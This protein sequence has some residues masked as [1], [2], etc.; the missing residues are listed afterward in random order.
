L[1]ANRFALFAAA[2]S[3]VT[4]MLNVPLFQSG[5]LQAPAQR[6]SANTPR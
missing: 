4:I 6:A 3:E 5:G 1:K 2:T